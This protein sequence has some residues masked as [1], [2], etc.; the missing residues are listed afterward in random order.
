MSLRRLTLFYENT[1]RG[2][3]SSLA[4]AHV[5]DAVFE[6]LV[7][8]RLCEQELTADHL[9]RRTVEL[10]C[11]SAQAAAARA[12]ADVLR[13]DE[14]EIFRRARNTKAH[15]V[16]HGATAADYQLATALEAL[17]GSLYLDG[18]SERLWDLFNTCWPYLPASG[19]RKAT[20]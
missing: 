13:E 15:R 9:H 5:G 3:L 10:V 2:E 1:H 18:Q 14:R 17:F 4:L 11:A 16:P 6:L 7:R 8:T 19:D 12:V 20:V